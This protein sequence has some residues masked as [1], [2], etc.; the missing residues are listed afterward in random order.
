MKNFIY[1]I[2]LLIIFFFAFFLIYKG[3][4]IEQGIKKNKKFT[5]SR[6]EKIQMSGKSWSRCSYYIYGTFTNS[7]TKIIK[8]SERKKYLGKEFLVEY[9]SLNLKNSNILIDYPIPDSV[10]TP[11]NGWQEIPDWIK[12]Q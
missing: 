1:W 5:I 4:S 8:D 2:I 10:S 12:K 11:P 3:N 9:D 6:I 7:E